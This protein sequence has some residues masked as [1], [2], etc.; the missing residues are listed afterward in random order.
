MALVL[1]WKGKSPSPLSNANSVKVLAE[2][3]E[4]LVSVSTSMPLTQKLKS[5]SAHL[6]ASLI[7]SVV[8]APV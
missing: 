7:F 5:S 4:P 2:I 8:V 3:I 1:P 6:I